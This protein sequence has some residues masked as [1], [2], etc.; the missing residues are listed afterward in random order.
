MKINLND[1]YLRSLKAP[2][3]GRLEVS[4]TKRNGLRF[5]LTPNGKS[6]WMYEKRV[7]GGVKRKHTFGSWPTISLADARAMALEI[8]AE[9]T[10]GIDRVIIA[11]D[12][13]LALEEARVSQRSVQ[14][15]INSY[16]DLHLSNLRTG[17]ERKRQ[18]EA[19]LLKHLNK[20]IE[21]LSRK[22]L[23]EAVDAKN[24][25]GKKVYANRIRSALLAFTNWAWQR[26]YLA[27]PIGA[28]VAKAIKETARE[29]VLTVEEIRE[30]WDTSFSMGAL[31]GP[32]LRLIFLTGQRRSEIIKLRWSEVDLDKSRI[33]KA[34]SQTKNGK[35]QITHLSPPALKELQTLVQTECEFVFSTTGKTPVSGISKMKRQLDFRLGNDFEPWRLHD[36]RTAMATALA[37]AGE[38]ETIVDRIQNHQ[39]TGSAPSAVA[40]VYNQSTQLP[41]RAK[42]LDKWAEIL[43]GK[44]SK[45][46]KLYGKA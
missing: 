27:D 42:A 13:Q 12:E 40:R 18:L 43:T 22:D 9:A 31:W 3:T 25:E 46:V 39:A 21:V 19:A 2:E 29:R 17:E 15:V 23:Q 41:Q 28:G 45:I 38:S 24:R 4:D 35:P 37:E 16:W 14:Q 10:R 6:S 7:K 5:R 32:I 34:G 11:Q 30:I 33:I 26:D 20:P 36:F 8:E 44:P 1:R